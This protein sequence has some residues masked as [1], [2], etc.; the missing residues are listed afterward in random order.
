MGFLT[1]SPSWFEFGFGLLGRFGGPL[2]VL[3]VVPADV[4]RHAR[5]RKQQRPQRDK[6]CNHQP[7]HK[8]QGLASGC[9]FAR[10]RGSSISGNRRRPEYQTGGHSRS[11][12]MRG[13]ARRAKR[14]A[15]KR[16]KP[17][18]LNSASIRI[19]GT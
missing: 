9:R 4:A 10:L 15:K 13:G 11:T 8:E 12:E 1:A 5:G 17:E 3:P 7:S 16:Q 2:A 19:G 14:E 6:K 18:K